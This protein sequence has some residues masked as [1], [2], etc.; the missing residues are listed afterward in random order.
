MPC[1][2][3]TSTGSWPLPRR[4]GCLSCTSSRRMWC[5][6]ASCPMALSR[7]TRCGERPPTWT[8]SSRVP[9]RR[10]SRGATDE[11]RASH[12]PQDREGAGVDAPA[13][14]AGARGRSDPIDE[15]RGA[16]AMSPSIANPR[17]KVVALILSG[18]FLGL[19]QLYNRQV[20]K[21]TM[22]LTVRVVLS[23]LLVRTIPIDPTA[24]AHAGAAPVVLLLVLLAIWLW[25][26]V[27]GWPRRDGEQA[28]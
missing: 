7:P 2:S 1:I 12:Q 26:L 9:S 25:S 21:G 4:I 20:L 22:F 6:A 27:D 5:G 28:R 18:V 15:G 8:R 24:L 23:W 13:G 14:A 17:R 10:S 16:A 19:G 3:F 11:V